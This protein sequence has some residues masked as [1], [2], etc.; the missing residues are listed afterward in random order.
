[1]IIE[2]RGDDG[3]MRSWGFSEE[4]KTVSLQRLCF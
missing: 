2:K 4:D 3:R 1:M